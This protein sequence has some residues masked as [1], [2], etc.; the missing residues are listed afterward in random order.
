MQRHNIDNLT[1]HYIWY[2]MGT[3]RRNYIRIS[4]IKTNYLKSTPFL[5]FS[6]NFSQ[7]GCWQ[8]EKTCCKQAQRTQRKKSVF[9]VRTIFFKYSVDDVAKLAGN[10]TS[11]G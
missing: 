10:R 11:S 3:Q 9:Y 8:D 4:K 1:K 5:K 2:I 6:K 7:R